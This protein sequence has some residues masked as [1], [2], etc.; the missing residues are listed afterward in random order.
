MNNNNQNPDKDGGEG[1]GIDRVFDKLSEAFDKAARGIDRVLGRNPPEAEKPQ[2]GK[3]AA[4]LD[5]DAFFRAVRRRDLG[6]IQKFIAAGFDLNT[7]TAAGD[8]ALHIAAR[9]NATALGQLLLD[10]GADPRAGHGGDTERTPLADAINFGKAEMAELLTRHGGYAPGV[11]SSTGLTLL[12][13]ACEKGKAGVV[14]AMI[15]AGADGNE[16]TGNGATPLIV[17]ISQRQAAVAEKLLD[18]P[19]VIQGVNEFF[20]ATDPKKRTAFQLA[21]EK[22]QAGVVAKMLAFGSNINAPDADGVT[23]LQHAV[24]KGNLALVRTLI[25]E[26]AD[27]NR[28]FPGGETPLHAACGAPEIADG[29]LRAT[30]VRCLVRAGADPDLALAAGSK[31][32][33][34]HL[35]AQAANGAEALAVL[36]EFKAQTERTDAQGSTPLFYAARRSDAAVLRQLLQAGADPNARHLQDARTPLI[37]AVR[38]NSAAAVRALL[39]FGA[40]PGAYDADGK[41]AL[42]YARER[43]QT[44]VIALLEAALNNREKANKPLP[45]GGDSEPPRS[46]N[47]ESPHGGDPKPPPPPKP[48]GTGFQE[49]SL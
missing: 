2:A 4:P 25:A 23:P 20:V 16:K 5:A 38:E 11:A 7:R 40:N 24:V 44:A 1:D 42:S 6:Q 22:G 26:G 43:K 33:P 47:S 45:R 14:E 8:T 3:P 28:P 27:L 32:T 18:F 12:H 46:G 10:A 19:A 39:D 31:A 41:S 37:E 29:A 30:L 49:W 13:R 15:K 35:A 48:P 17:A 21:V 34:L 9:D 36:L